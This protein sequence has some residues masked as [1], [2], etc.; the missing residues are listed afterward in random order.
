MSS[1]RLSRSG[2]SPLWGEHVHRYDVAANSVEPNYTVLDIASGTGFGTELLAEKTGGLVV[3]ADVSFGAAAAARR[4]GSQA[5]LRYITADGTALPFPEGTFDLLT[6]FETIEHTPHYREMLREFRRVVKPGG[7]VMISTPNR[8]V[9]SPTGTIENPFHTQEFDLEEFTDLLREAF[10]H[11]RVLGQRYARY[12]DH[13]PEWMRFV[14]R[15]LEALLYRR[16]IRKLPLAL[17]DLA[18]KPF[19]ISSLYPRPTDFRLVE[20]PSEIRMCKTFVGLCR[21]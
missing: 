3:G 1:E 10:D 16:G 21:R 17:R 14:A 12:D 11:V 15:R 20:A 9:N 8:A 13:A 2:P 5:N 6:S 19:G 18:L 4:A 7:T